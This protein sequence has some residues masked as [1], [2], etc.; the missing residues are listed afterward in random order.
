MQHM[1]SMND[2]VSLENLSSLH[3]LQKQICDLTPVK[4]DGQLRVHVECQQGR[5]RNAVV[6][7]NPG[8]N[9]SLYLYL[10]AQGWLMSA[11]KGSAVSWELPLI[12]CIADAIGTVQSRIEV[13]LLPRPLHQTLRSNV[14]QGLAALY[15]DKRYAA[16]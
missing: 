3:D 5:H 16:S 2:Q 9:R 1:T 10:T 13:F 4:I 14:K 12:G 7:S 11:Q 15:T 8:I 6:I